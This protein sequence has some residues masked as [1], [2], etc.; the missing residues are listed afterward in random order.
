MKV[1]EM[2]SKSATGWFKI[3]DIIVNP[4]KFQAMVMSSDKKEKYIM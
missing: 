3:N 4:N 2:E 1:L